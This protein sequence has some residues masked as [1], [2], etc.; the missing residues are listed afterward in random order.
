MTEDAL[1][2]V[3]HLG[4]GRIGEGPKRK[5]C[6]LAGLHPLYLTELTRDY[7]AGRLNLQ[8]LPAAELM[9]PVSLE[10]IFNA[11]IQH[12][13]ARSMKVAGL[14]AVGARPLRVDAI[15]TLAGLALDEATD[16]IEELRR[17]RLVESD[18]DRVRIVHELF[19]S[20][21]Y[22][23]LGDPRRALHHRAVAAHILAEGA[24]ESSGELAIHYARAGECELA[25][26][27]GWLAADRAM[28][29]GTVAEAV[30]LYQLVIDN[31]RDG[32]RR[33]D[34]TA[35][36]ARAL[37]LGRDITRANPILELA[38]GQLR[39]T[40]RGA[41]ALRLDIKRIEGLAEV[42]AVPISALTQRLSQ[43]KHQAAQ[44]SDW[45]AVAL[46]RC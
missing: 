43:L 12:L 20:A 40:G 24:E 6:A 3:D 33:A 36:L 17:A 34:A 37:H 26:R 13:D 27:Y 19:R 5:I 29:T 39:A 1:L 46:V 14:L 30:H 15:A 32:G 8:E 2:L 35:G 42:G 25:A 4:G 18:Y 28:E 23:N 41:D 45:E 16:A 22:R 9:I 7:L 11:R 21:I 31:E 44:G 10:Q 38:A